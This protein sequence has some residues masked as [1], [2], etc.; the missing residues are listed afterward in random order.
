MID[1]LGSG[2]FD[3]AAAMDVGATLGR[4]T[5]SSLTIDGRLVGRPAII[6]NVL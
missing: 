1:E 5:Q 4:S 2:C 3:G 6:E